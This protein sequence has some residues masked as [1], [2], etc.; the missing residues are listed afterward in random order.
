MGTA[1]WAAEAGSGEWGTLGGPHER[2]R[3]VMAD[4]TGA[5][6]RYKKPSVSPALVL[7][8]VHGRLPRGRPLSAR[9][10]NWFLTDF[11]YEVEQVSLPGGS[12]ISHIVDGR[13]DANVTNEWLSSATLQY[14]DLEDE[15][16]CV[17]G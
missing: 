11:G 8:V 14:N 5:G 15:G 6:E 4:R 7:G 9:W 13:I 1:Q 17:F 12:F 3:R 16:G 10:A 2:W